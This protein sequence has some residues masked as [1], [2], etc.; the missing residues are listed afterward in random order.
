MK[1]IKLIGIMSEYGMIA[2]NKDYDSFEM[3]ITNREI[4]EEDLE[5]LRNNLNP[6]INETVYPFMSP[7]VV[8]PYFNEEEGRVKLLIQQGHHRFIICKEQNRN[9]NYVVTTVSD[10]TLGQNLGTQDWKIRDIVYSKMKSGDWCYTEVYNLME[11]YEGYFSYTCL[12][13]AIKGKK[14][15]G[16]NDNNINLKSG[17]FSFTEEELESAKDILEKYKKFNE[18]MGY[19]TTNANL[20]KAMYDAN[21]YPDFDWKHFYDRSTKPSTQA[22]INSNFKEVNSNA[23]ARKVITEV[24]NFG[25]RTKIFTY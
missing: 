15:S 16:K 18:L 1:S 19:T 11:K 8:Y 9:V 20:L 4:Y 23:V 22:R 21:T 5:S 7:I 13:V 24:Y 2:T 12:T 6:D 17:K 25:S 3:N 14:L 10:T